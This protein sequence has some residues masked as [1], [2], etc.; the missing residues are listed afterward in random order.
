[1]VNICIGVYDKPDEKSHSHRQIV[2]TFHTYCMF[3]LDDFPADKIHS[4]SMI[5][6]IQ[7]KGVAYEAVIN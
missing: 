5:G 1:M 6:Q 2:A 7:I 4:S 3:F